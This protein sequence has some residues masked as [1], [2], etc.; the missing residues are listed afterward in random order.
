MKRKPFFELNKAFV[1][2]IW[3]YVTLQF[4]LVAVKH[5]SVKGKRNLTNFVFSEKLK[6]KL[7][8][9]FCGSQQNICEKQKIWFHNSK[10]LIFQE[11]FKTL[12]H[13]IWLGIWLN[14][15]SIRPLLPQYSQKMVL[16]VFSECSFSTNIFPNFRNPE[17]WF[18]PK[19]GCGIRVRQKPIGL[20][21]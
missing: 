16:W 3:F 7:L 10:M 13:D 19:L 18:F 14:P 9:I 12:T 5:F 4:S 20:E 6:K 8:W 11:Y 17:I 1:F 15:F 21:S 2:D